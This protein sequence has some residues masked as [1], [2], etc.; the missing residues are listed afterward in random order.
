MTTGFA[1]GPLVAGILAQWAPARTVLPYLPHLVL[2]IIA[3]GLVVGTA[4]T[5]VAPQG[6]RLPDVR[7]PRFRAVVVPLAP[8][9]FASAS[10]ALA[11]LPGLV[12]SRVGGYALVYSAGVITLA[13]LAGI[14]VQPLARRLGRRLLGIS[15]A[16]VI[17]GLLV[18]A[19]AAAVSAPV[20]VV[21]AALVLG[22]GYGSCQ[23][24]GL[25][26]VQRLAHPDDLAGLTAVYQAISYL[27]LTTP[28]LLAAVQS[29]AAPTVLLLAVAALAALTLVWTTRRSRGADL[30]EAAAERGGH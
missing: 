23:V 4:E 10:I 22:S 24:C 30:V 17:A 14:L 12:A 7:Q 20:L 6:F 9:V 11:Y 26:E 15:L 28:F 8:W 1:A 19:L 3:I 5:R 21:V 2:A 27:G 13:A 16:I 25:I 29:V 18:A